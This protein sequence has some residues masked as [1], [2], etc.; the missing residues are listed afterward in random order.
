GGAVPEIVSIH[1]ERE[2]RPPRGGARR[3]E[4]DQRGR[5]GAADAGPAHLR[6]GIA[7][8]LVV[9]DLHLVLTRRDRAADRVGGRGLVLPLVDDGDAVE[10]HADAVAGA[11]RERLVT[12]P[13]A[14]RAR[15]AHGELV[16]GQAR[17]AG[18]PV[19]VVDARRHL[20]LPSHGGW[21][22]RHSVVV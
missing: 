6:D 22:P 4:G 1:D 21:C 19:I 3:A 15:P 12:T 11:G 7:A 20:A 2:G 9:L 5:A 17:G 8:A 16:D 10:E 18:G 14:E 13:A